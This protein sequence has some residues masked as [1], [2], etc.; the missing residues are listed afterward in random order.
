MLNT[1]THTRVRAH[2]HTHTHTW[3]KE[4]VSIDIKMC[5]W[6]LPTGEYGGYWQWR[7]SN[8]VQGFPSGSVVKNSLLSNEGSI[9]GSERSPG[10]GQGDPLQYSC[11]ENP[12]D[13]GDWQAIV[14]VKLET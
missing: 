12:M 2:T 7:G 1:H 4:S 6:L 11:L 3:V 5:Q 10:G 14:Y 13:R 9:L 8:R